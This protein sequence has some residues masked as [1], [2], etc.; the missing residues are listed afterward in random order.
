MNGR[1]L[2]KDAVTDTVNSPEL[3]SSLR[4]IAS[5][6]SK[7]RYQYGRRGLQHP[8]QT[9][10][11]LLVHDESFF[12][13]G[14][15]RVK[16]RGNLSQLPTTTLLHAGELPN[17]LTGEWPAFY[18][19]QIVNSYSSCPTQFSNS[20]QVLLFGSLTMYFDVRYGCQCNI[21]R[22]SPIRL[23]CSQKYLVLP[24][25]ILYNLRLIQ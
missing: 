15:S 22:S 21:S 5:T 7:S 9:L 3:L 20:S 6:Y 11:P 4:D 13:Q 8:Q 16:R 18:G 1:Y 2:K 19:C 24:T 17:F 25:K 23:K 10:Q 12:F 14:T